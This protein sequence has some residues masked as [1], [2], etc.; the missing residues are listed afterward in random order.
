L[1]APPAVV[2]KSRSRGSFSKYSTRHGAQS[3]SISFCGNCSFDMRIANESKILRTKVEQAFH[4][5]VSV[6]SSE[7]EESL[8]NIFPGDAVRR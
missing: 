7:A 5:S 8:D 6:I 4:V 3:V 2:R 1:L